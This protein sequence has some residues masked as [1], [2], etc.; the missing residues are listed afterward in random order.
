MKSAIVINIFIL[1]LLIIGNNSSAQQPLVL[2]DAI[3]IA[4]RNSLDI[5]LAKN[6][7][8]INATLN[9]YG[10]A[11]GLPFVSGTASDNEQVTSISQK[12][13]NGIDIKRNGATGNSLSA[14]IGAGILLY[15]GMRVI[16]TKN[17]LA[18]LQMQSEKYLN[19]QIQNTIALVMNGYYDVVRQQSYIKTI[20]QSIAVAQQKLDIVKVQ[21]S[22]GLANN[23]DLF[24]SELDLNALLQTQQSQQL[25]IDQTRTE[26]LRELN[27][28]PDSAVII[29]DTILIDSTLSLDNILVSMQNN[30][31]IMAANDQIKINEFI[32]KETA[33][34][35]YP[36]V[37]FNSGY[38][39]NRAQNSAGNNLFNKSYG[40]FAN[41]SL[42]IPI[43]NGT[44]NKRQQRVAEINTHNAQI[45]KQNLVKDYTADAVKM[46]Q[47]YVS[48]LKQLQ[49][50]KEDYSLAQQLLSLVLQRFQLRVAT[51]VDV[52]LAQQSFEN[53]GYVLINISFAAKSEE[54]EL[55]RLAN[56]LS[57]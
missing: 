31:D 14:G 21:Q 30:A 23:A 34:L 52:K 3:N 5:Q 39:Y 15:N 36:S 28:K 13:S 33:A 41:L 17:R 7:V 25:I 48:N 1:L 6:N 51:I 19:A 55:K 16:A 12:L 54:I 47:A 45:Q 22:V 29:Q 37:N 8:S 27:L 43:Y 53:A 2:Q 24:Q 40:P 11:G 10:V 50:A 4:L 20:Q 46:Y 26:L 18:Q 38:N 57:F 32:E 44:A 35:R 9:N 42:S 49:T 56:T